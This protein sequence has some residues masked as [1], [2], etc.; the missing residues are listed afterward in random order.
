MTMTNSVTILNKVGDHGK[1]KASI[2][3]DRLLER[4]I[5]FMYELVGNCH[6]I[7]V[8]EQNVSKAMEY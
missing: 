7:T 6:T 8:S 2:L 1:L 5:T 3:A 4:G